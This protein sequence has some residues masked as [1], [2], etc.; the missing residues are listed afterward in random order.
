[1]PDRPHKI[2]LAFPL[3]GINVSTGYMK[4]PPGTTPVGVNV[5]AFDAGTNR[6]RGGCR[7][8]LTPFL[9]K[10]STAQ[11]AGFFPIQHLAIIIWVDPAAVG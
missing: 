5:R 2:E 4:Q 11:V 1:M 8:G 3:G 10:G 9:G 7:P 6:M